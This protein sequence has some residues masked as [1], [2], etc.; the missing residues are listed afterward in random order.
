MRCADGDESIYGYPDWLALTEHNRQRDLGGMLG[1]VK[2]AP[3]AV[4]I[5][6]IILGLILVLVLPIFWKRDL[7]QRQ[8]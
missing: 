5:G 1:G 6:A 7:P 8:L 2:G 4:S 3:E